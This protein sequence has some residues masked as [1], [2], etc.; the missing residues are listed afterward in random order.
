M[1]LFEQGHTYRRRDL[2]ERFGGQQQGGIVTPSGHPL[3]LV[4]TGEAGSAYGYDDGWESDGT[5]RYSGEGQ[6]GDMQF[7][8]GNAAIR[9]HAA[10]S[11]ELHL[12][13]K[14]PP[15]HLRYVG[16]MVCAGHDLVPG[17]PDRNGQPRT[18]ITFR[19]APLPAQA[20]TDE[21]EAPADESGATVPEDWYWSADLDTLRAAAQAGAS[22]SLKPAQARRNVYHRSA[23]LRAYVLRRADGSCEGCNQPAPFNTAAGRPYL[24]AHHTLHLSDGGPDDPAAVIALC[25]T[26]H[27]RVHHGAD[28]EAYNEL[29]IA[30]LGDI[31]H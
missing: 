5:F 23:A 17:V 2:H 25:P 3:I 28:G 10:N 9:D 24:E 12:F 1:P 27:R 18:A 19:L 6:V 14:S 13:E 20:L 21:P 31:E 30:S 11:R 4:I 16:Q 15:A 29:L 8:R 22:T 7:V 26:C